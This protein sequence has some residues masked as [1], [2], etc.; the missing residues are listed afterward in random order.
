MHILHGSLFLVRNKM[1]C[2]S[3]YVQKTEMISFLKYKFFNKVEIKIIKNED[4]ESESLLQPQIFALELFY[5]FCRSC[6]DDY[7]VL[8]NDMYFSGSECGSTND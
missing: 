8:H 5:A 4:E 1:N 3:C 7:K 6:W 2:F